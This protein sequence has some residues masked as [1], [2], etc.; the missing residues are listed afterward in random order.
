[1]K[2]LSKFSKIGIVILAASIGVGG[3]LTYKHQQKQRILE[4]RQ[5]YKETYDSLTIDFHDIEEIEYGSAF[6]L[7]DLVKDYSG[8]LVRNGE[9]DS[10][11]VGEYT[12]MYALSKEEEKYAQDITRTYFKTVKV[13]D[14]Q[15][16]IISLQEDE[17]TIE[18]G[19]EYEP[20]DNIDKVEDVVDGKLDE[21][22]YTVE[23][24][25]DNTTPGEYTLTVK[26]K[27]KNGL[28]AKK[29]F[30]VIVEEKKVQIQQVAANTAG[31]YDEIYNY[32]T[33]TL[34]YSKAMSCGIIAN[35]YLESNFIPTVGDYYYGLC[36]W[37]GGRRSNLF[38]W[39]ESNGLDPNSVVG[40]L[41]YMNYELNTGYTSCKSQ[42]MAIEDS[43][44]GAAMAADIFCRQFEGAAVS[45]RGDLAASYYDLP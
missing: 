1:M 19:E 12:I 14:T 39:C 9:I 15:A 13:V 29:E 22:A 43:K 8:H 3:F 2:K 25:F 11:T 31:N 35:I 23:G 4:A 40:Q 42:L 16:P 32:L 33:G 20:I 28:S 24:N 27:D 10:K 37:G 18:E 6:S 7:G 41:E 45:S 26:A 5:L 44:E 38:S 30:K 21:K 17:I 34:G 36:Q